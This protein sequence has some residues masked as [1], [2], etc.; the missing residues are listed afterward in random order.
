MPATDMADHDRSRVV[1][2]ARL[3]SAH[4]QL[5]LPGLLCQPRE[6]GD[7]HVSAGRSIR[8]ECFNGHTN[9]ARVLHQVYLLTAVQRHD[10][11]L[12]IQT[13]AHGPAEAANLAWDVHRAHGENLNF[14][15]IF[16][17][18]PDVRLGGVGPNLEDI[19]VLLFLQHRASLRQ[20]G[21]NDYV[22]R[23]EMGHINLN[24]TL[25]SPGPP[26]S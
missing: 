17:R 20:D 14:E 24:A 2:A 12:P 19:L 9:A 5:L 23:V 6:H 16:H 4:G 22:V 3:A 13:L 8:L 10:G 15:Y 18:V 11:L 21:P 7:R 1:T 26:S 25:V